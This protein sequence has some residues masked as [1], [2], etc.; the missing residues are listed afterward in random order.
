MPKLFELQEYL[1]NAGARNFL[2]ID[3]PPIE[4]S[5]AGEY[6]GTPSPQF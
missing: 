5:P 2:F 1:Y 6:Y 4:R 3:L